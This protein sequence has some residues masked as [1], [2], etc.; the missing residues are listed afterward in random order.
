M[1]CGSLIDSQFPIWQLNEL[2]SYINDV[3][4]QI[5]M[6][7]KQNQW[8]MFSLLAF[9]K[10]YCGFNSSFKV[11]FFHYVLDNAVCKLKLVMCTLF[12]PESQN[13]LWFQCFSSKMSITEIEI[14]GIK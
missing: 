7:M 14:I 2:N 13:I 1:I 11:Q 3:Q 10:F 6:Q 8:T 4:V 5:R 9:Y 12:K